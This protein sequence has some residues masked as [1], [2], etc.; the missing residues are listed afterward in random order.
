M[1]HQK[2]TCFV[3][4]PFGEPFD[5]YYDQIYKPAIEAA[6][7]ESVRGDQVYGTGA[8][9]DD[10]FREIL[11]SKLVLCEV[12]GK[13]PNVNYELGIAHALKKPAVIITQDFN[14]VPFDYRHLRVIIYNQK[15]VDWVQ[16]LN[17]AISKTILSVLS[18]PNK[19]LA[20]NPEPQD[21]L[22]EENKA[23]VYKDITISYTPNPSSAVLR[24]K[25]QFVILGARSGDVHPGFK[26][27]FIEIYED[28]RKLEGRIGKEEYIQLRRIHHDDKRGCLLISIDLIHNKETLSSFSEDQLKEA[29]HDGSG[30]YGGQLI[31]VEANIIET[32]IWSDNFFPNG[33][34][35]YNR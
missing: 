5:E 13:N 29:L 16:Q 24:Y 32:W 28:V 17:A 35:Y 9:I 26:S 18:S 11:E 20:W 15:K 21:E 12:T 25:N 22:K 8:I 1:S 19:A 23:D 3:I 2:P 14:D 4:S 30:W 27:F 33:P 6:N 10:I 7:L 31:F 34:E